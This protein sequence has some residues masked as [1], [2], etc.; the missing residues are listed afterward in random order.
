M[1]N[2]RKLKEGAATFYIYDVNLHHRDD[3]TFILWLKSEG[4][5]LEMF[6]HGNCEHGIYVNINSKVYTWGMGGVGLSPI[7]GNHAIHIEEFK[8]IYGIFKKY[9]GFIGCIYSEEE[10][11]AYDNRQTQLLI[12]REC[13][14]NAKREYF[15]KNPSFEKWLD[16][17]AESII[18]DPWYKEHWPNYT[19]QEILHEAEDKCIRGMLEK[20]YRDQDMPGKIASE[21]DIIT[22]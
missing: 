12:L 16:D 14:E 4:F 6:G 18:R 11:K 22:M 20:Y 8:Q 3:D 10:Q 15:S 9:S 2:E 13:A 5:S 21:W 19:K 7:I 17:I 1:S